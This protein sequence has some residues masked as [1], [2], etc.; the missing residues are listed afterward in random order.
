MTQQTRTRMTAA[1][2][3]R[4]MAE[5]FADFCKETPSSPGWH[6]MADYCIG[7]MMQR[8]I[9]DLKDECRDGETMGEKR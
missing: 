9:D 1:E 5:L 4:Y 3:L 6:Q 2:E 7:I 8:H